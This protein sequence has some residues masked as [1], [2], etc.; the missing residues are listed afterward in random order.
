LVSEQSRPF[1]TG[2]R[3]YRDP[4]GRFFFRYPLGWH[5]HELVD[6]RDGIMYSPEASDPETYF[7]TWA[8]RLE[9]KVVAEDMDIL[10]EGVDEGLY[11]LP[12][13]KLE[14]SA[15]QTFGNLIRF[16]RMYTIDE[17]GATRQRKVWMIYVYRWL[18]VLVAQGASPETYDYWHMML[19]GCFDSFD[20]AQ[21]LWYASDREV[22]S[23]LA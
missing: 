18:F 23:D 8:V 19:N 13:L 17:D 15:D 14:S 3:T 12:G 4:V 20:L 1:Y 2:L 10:R 6:N 11:Q 16:E 5:Q 22:A 9:H 21:E 7:A